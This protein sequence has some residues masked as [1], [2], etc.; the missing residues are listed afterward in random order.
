MGSKFRYGD[1]KV[2]G[3]QPHPTHGLASSHCVLRLNL[4]KGMFNIVS[5]AH[6]HTHT[7]TNMHLTV[8]MASNIP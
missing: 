6:I 7:H 3:T 8:N 5:Y 1:G 2:L 4:I